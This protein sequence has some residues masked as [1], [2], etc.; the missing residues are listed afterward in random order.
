MAQAIEGVAMDDEHQFIDIGADQ[1]YMLEDKV[2]SR[3][4]AYIGLM[5]ELNRVDNP[6]I[7]EE[8]LKMLER[9][10]LSVS[11]PQP[12]ISLV[13]NDKSH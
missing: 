3:T 4:Y 12:S 11:P 8:G 5:L 6:E 1:P 13:K 10:R 9:I 7:M 2:A